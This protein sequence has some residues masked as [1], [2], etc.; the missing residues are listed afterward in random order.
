MPVISEAGLRISAIFRRVVPDPFVIAVLLTLVTGAVALIFGSW[1][2][3]AANQSPVVA[4]LDAW[5]GDAGIWAFLKFSM[6]MCLIL[7]TGYALAESTPVRW[8]IGRLVR[9]PRNTAQAAVLV[10][11]VACVFGVINWGLGLIV[12]ALLA[13]DVGRSLRERGIRAH[14]PLIVAAGYLGLLVWHGG[15]SGSA[16]LK[17]STLKELAGT[18][19]IDELDRIG[20]AEG[21]SLGDTLG[22]GMNLIITA[23]LVIGA[24]LLL[25][26]FAPKSEADM[27]SAPEGSPDSPPRIDD[28]DAE[29]STL[30]ER[31]FGSPIVAW[32]LAVPLILS[33]I[34]YGKET[35]L[36]RLGPNEIVAIMFGIGLICHG[37]LR[38]YARA[39]EDGARS[40]AGIILQFPL[41]AGIMGMLTASGLVHDI[42]HWFVETGNETTIPLMT[43]FSAAVVNVFVPSGGGQWGIQGLIALETAQEA[44]IDPGKMIMAVVYGDELT[45][46]L[47]PF[48]ALPLLAITGVKARDIVGYTAMVMVAAGAWMAIGLLV[49]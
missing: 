8:L 39:A 37:S 12:G 21:I 27:R 18:F 2:N 5:R 31:L 32:L 34:R 19:G 41:Y 14:Y 29:P 16:P 6:Q 28:R 46:M 42:S 48:W 13:R 1:P 36:G 30:P 24:P 17:A 23:G 15:L 7:V 35:G 43:F 11:M 40:C 47:Q 3:A 49:F 4:V 33:F 38:T 26:L 10:G 9:L 45:N 22:S 20:I 25:M 44:G